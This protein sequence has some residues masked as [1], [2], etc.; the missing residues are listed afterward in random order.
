M[1]ILPAALGFVLALASRRVRGIAAV[2]EDRAFRPKLG[3]IFFAVWAVLAFLKSISVIW[4]ID[5][6]LAGRSGVSM[7][8]RILLFVEMSFVSRGTPGPWTGSPERVLIA[9][10]VSSLIWAGMVA[11]FTGAFRNLLRK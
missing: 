1:I 3:T 10:A 2:T 11:A 4:A 9:A 8:S 6:N 7:M 5:E